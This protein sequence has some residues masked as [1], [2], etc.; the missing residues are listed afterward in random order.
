MD[1]VGI[2]EMAK[3]MAGDE[4]NGVK[5]KFGTDSEYINLYFVFHHLF[6]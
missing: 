3:G 4:S 5:S 6:Q 2:Q 1:M